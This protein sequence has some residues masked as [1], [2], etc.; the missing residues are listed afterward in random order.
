MSIHFQ[1]ECLIARCALKVREIS[2]CRVQHFGLSERICKLLNVDMKNLETLKLDYVKLHGSFRVNENAPLLKTLA[3]SGAIGVHPSIS[4]S[5]SALK[6]M[7]ELYMGA[8]KLESW[9]NEDLNRLWS[10][11]PSLE[12][13][14][15]YEDNSFSAMN[16]DAEK[17]GP[18][19][20]RLL[21]LGKLRSLKKLDLCRTACVNSEVEL[22]N[23]FSE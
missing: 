14:R 4:V 22:K 3:L 20:E 18:V 12:K 17:M 11:L 5:L 21:S 7:R 2:L 1:L 13:L 19:N 8:M 16:Y 9:T 10:G 15:F 6:N 23:E